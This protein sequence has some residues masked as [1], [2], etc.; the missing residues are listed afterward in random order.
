MQKDL[1]VSSRSMER[2][3]KK[4]PLTQDSYARGKNRRYEDISCV[5]KGCWRSRC[6]RYRKIVPRVLEASALCRNLRV[7]C[8]RTQIQF[9]YCPYNNAR[10]CVVLILV[11]V[12]G[13]ARSM[14]PNTHNSTPPSRYFRA[15]VF[16]GV[17]P[18][19]SSFEEARR[20]LVFRPASIRRYDQKPAR[21]VPLVLPCG[22]ATLGRTTNGE[23]LLCFV[24]LF[25]TT[26][27][28]RS[29]C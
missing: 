18:Q 29:N 22:S 23:T 20:V 1:L 13:W 2:W 24:L 27:I 4:K 17:V 6:V 3:N 19:I 25:L 16:V 7:K 26:I 9:F 15:S 5:H 21:F 10:A 28:L 14:V 8:R 11:S 12:C